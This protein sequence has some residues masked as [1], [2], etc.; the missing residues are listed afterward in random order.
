MKDYLS[1]LDLKV[2]KVLSKNFT[3]PSA[4]TVVVYKTHFNIGSF[5]IS[6]NNLGQ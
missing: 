5:L 1:L 3:S 6:K 4:N 2:I